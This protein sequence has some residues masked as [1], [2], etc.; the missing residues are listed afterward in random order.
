MLRVAASVAAG[1]VDQS[2]LPDATRFL[3]ACLAR[4]RCPGRSLRTRRRGCGTRDGHKFWL[5][6]DPCGL[7]CAALVHAIVLFCAYSTTTQVIIPW[8]APTSAAAAWFHALL[9]NTL[10][11]L[12]LLS[13]VRAM[14]SNPGA[15]P[16]NARPTAPEGWGKECGKCRAFKP[17][18]A[19]HCSICGRCVIKMGACAMG[20]WRGMAGMG[21]MGARVGAAGAHG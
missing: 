10:A 7:F 17:P 14:L 20:G 18:R 8:F 6:F 16:A 12:G 9:F 21:G 3:P 15:V 19:H 11:A 5:N 4:A 1:C 2:R 13:H